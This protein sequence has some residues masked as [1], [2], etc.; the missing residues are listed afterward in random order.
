MTLPLL[1]FEKPWFSTTEVADGIFCLTEPFVTRF[2]RSNIWFLR[3]ADADLLVD[4]GNGISRLPPALPAHDPARLI[5]VATHV[6]ADHTGGLAEFPDIWCN[7]IAVEALATAD[8]AETLA[9]PGY[10]INDVAGLIV[11]PPRLSGPLATARPRDFDPVQFGPRPCT[12]GRGLREGDTVGLGSR[13]FGVLEVPG[14]SPACIA[15][16]DTRDGLLIA[17]DAIYDGGLVDGLF[18][19][20]RVTYRRSLERLLALPVDLVLGGHGQPMT[21]A[22]MAQLIRGYLAG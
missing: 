2:M 11:P 12:V 1:P 19:S 13:T 22:R 7:A 8:P 17:G 9:G 3:G 14:H 20:D 5:V 6:H 10:A 21:G 16:Y 4:T 15:L 18:H